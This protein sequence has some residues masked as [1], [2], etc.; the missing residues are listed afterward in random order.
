MRSGGFVATDSK[1]GWA[2]QI[3]VNGEVIVVHDK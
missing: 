2:T 1:G 3:A